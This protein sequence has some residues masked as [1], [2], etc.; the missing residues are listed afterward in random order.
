MQNSIW[1]IN[2]FYSRFFSPE[3]V[4]L[5][6]IVHLSEFFPLTFNVFFDCPRKYLC[7]RVLCTVM[8]LV[9]NY[10]RNIVKH[11]IQM[12]TNGLGITI[13]IHGAPF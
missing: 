6:L 10:S 2:L 12:R 8:P 13:S 5:F 7:M 1:N 9:E 3:V 11:S 4:Q